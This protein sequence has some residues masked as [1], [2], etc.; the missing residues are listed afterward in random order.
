LLQKEERIV[1]LMDSSH[2][3]RHSVNSFDLLDRPLEMW[4]F[5]LQAL[6][7]QFVEPLWQIELNPDL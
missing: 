3:H 4:S 5:D 1:V 2:D 6:P 7:Q